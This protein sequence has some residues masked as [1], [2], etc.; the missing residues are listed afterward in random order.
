MNNKTNDIWYLILMFFAYLVVS[1]T[2]AGCTAVET[3]PEKLH[4]ERVV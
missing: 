4:H 2:I 1:S 3:A